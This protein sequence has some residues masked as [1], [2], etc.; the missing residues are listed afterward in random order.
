MDHPCYS[1]KNDGVMGK[2]KDEKKGKIIVEFV[3]LRAKQYSV[4]DEDGSELKKAKGIAKATLKKHT[5]ED[6]K[7]TLDGEMITRS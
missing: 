4:L 6:Y 3:G 2:M 5:F 7:T 1:K